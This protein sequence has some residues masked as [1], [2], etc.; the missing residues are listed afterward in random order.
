MEIRRKIL[1]LRPVR[2]LLRLAS[3]MSLDS[4]PSVLPAIVFSDSII[5]EIGTQKRSIIGSFDQFAFPQFPAAYGRFF[6]TVWIANM[7]GTL[8]E[9]DITVRIEQKGS[10]HVVF[11]TTLKIPFGAERPFERHNVMVFSIPVPQVTFPSS[12]TYTASVRINAEPSG[13]KDFNVI[14]T[15]QNTNV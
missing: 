1:G 10:A 3:R 15:P 5:V 7:Q 11:S 6:I 8:S 13:E 9:M 2:H 14:Q 4:E 12:G